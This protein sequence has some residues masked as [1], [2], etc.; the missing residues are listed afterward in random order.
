MH[1]VVAQLVERLVRNEKVR[2]STPLGST[3]LQGNYL[4]IYKADS[5]HIY[6]VFAWFVFRFAPGNVQG[7]SEVKFR[8]NATSFFQM[9]AG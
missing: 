2:G 3:M 6:P 1:G 8:S 5:Q 7:V 9:D 4:G